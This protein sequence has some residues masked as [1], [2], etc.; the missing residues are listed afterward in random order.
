MPIS[1]SSS[2]ASDDAESLLSQDETKY[3]FERSRF[4]QRLYNLV[5]K[6]LLVLSILILMGGVMFLMA[7]WT[8][9][10]FMDLSGN[11]KAHGARIANI[12]GGEHGNRCMQWQ[13]TEREYTF[14]GVHR[15][16]EKDVS[17]AEYLLKDLCGH[18][19]T[20]ARARGCRFGMLY[21]AWLLEV[22]YDE[23]IEEEFKNYTDWQFWLYPNRTG[24]VTWDEAARRERDF[25]LVER[26]HHQR[27][28][29]DMARKFYRAVSGRGLLFI[30]SVL[31]QKGYLDHCA[32]V[33]LDRK[34]PIHELNTI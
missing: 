6:A 13:D 16:N 34:R 18:S 23:E 21:F 32:G 4:K 1:Q 12:E 17:G 9:F 28:C 26:E 19:A 15:P 22:C 20:E 2:S 31:L 14:G 11:S 30:D 27:H 10:G 8:I 24:E 3:V 25:M 29:V 5:T 33:A 7:R